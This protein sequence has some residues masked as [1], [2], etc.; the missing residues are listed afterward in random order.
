MS[1]ISQLS[2][3]L[4]EYENNLVTL[5]QIFEQ[6]T[7][8]LYQQIQQEFSPIYATLPANSCI[9]VRAN[10]WSNAYNLYANQSNTQGIETYKNKMSNDL[11]AIYQ[12][13]SNIN[14]F[15]GVPADCNIDHVL[16]VISNLS[17]LTPSNLDSPLSNLMSYLYVVQ[18]VERTIS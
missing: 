4:A 12:A 6:K 17:K 13:R 15:V 8:P 14:A 1:A 10:A 11:V 3:L 2:D 18:S 9:L 16:S 5:T 7:L